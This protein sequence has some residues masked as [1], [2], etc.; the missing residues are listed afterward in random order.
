VQ[1]TALV[2]Q[3]AEAQIIT[4]AQRWKFFGCARRSN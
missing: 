1:A 3:F 4:I 2:H